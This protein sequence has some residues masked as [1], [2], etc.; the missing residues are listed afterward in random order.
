LAEFWRELGSVFLKVSDKVET[1]IGIGLEELL[2]IPQGEVAFA[3][4]QPPG[5]KISIVAFFDFGEK[6]EPVEK[7]LEKAV[8]ALE[9]QGAKRSEEEQDD[10]RIILFK[11]PAD[12][13]S[14]KKSSEYFDTLA[15]CMKDSFLL[16]GT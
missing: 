6:R 16:V 7:L 4:V 8:A 3:A 15:Y 13:D 12:E 14:K 11:K 5:K 1:E 10:A 2:S 9:E